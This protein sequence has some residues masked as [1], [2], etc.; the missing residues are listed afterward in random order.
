MLL[1]FKLQL[2]EVLPFLK[3]CWVPDSPRCPL[4]AIQLIQPLSLLN[5]ECQ[6]DEVT[7]PR[8]PS[9]QVVESA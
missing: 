8:S 3:A 6:R 5:E 9:W 7:W 2:G 1:P 4:H